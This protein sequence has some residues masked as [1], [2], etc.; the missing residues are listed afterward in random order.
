MSYDMHPD[1][2]GCDHLE[3]FSGMCKAGKEI[4]RV[5][6]RYKTEESKQAVYK[7]KGCRRSDLTGTHSNAEV[8]RVEGLLFPGA[9]A[10]RTSEQML[11]DILELLGTPRKSTHTAEEIAN[12]SLY[13]VDWVINNNGK[14]ACPHCGTIEHTD[15][16]C[17]FLTIAKAIEEKY[18]NRTNRHQ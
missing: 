5:P 10:P 7:K 3:H 18:E 13:R 1:C 2:V 9:F 15:I 11:G 17:P 14:E 6:K 16:W 12:E 8:N 4:T